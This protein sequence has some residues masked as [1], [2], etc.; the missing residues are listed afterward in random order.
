M[1]FL[2]KEKEDVQI[3]HGDNFGGQLAFYKGFFANGIYLYLYY[4]CFFLNNYLI[5]LDNSI[6]FSFS[7]K[8]V[9]QSD[10]CIQNITSALNVLVA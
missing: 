3:L 1:L 4:I 9:Q 8:N 6:P 7:F 5:I 2:V 10:S